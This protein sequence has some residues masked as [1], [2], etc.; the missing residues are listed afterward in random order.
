MGDFFPKKFY[1][2]C[3]PSFSKKVLHLWV[4]FSKTLPKVIEFILKA[5]ESQN[6]EWELFQIRQL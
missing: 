3:L 5:G 1:S 2:I 6:W 4:I